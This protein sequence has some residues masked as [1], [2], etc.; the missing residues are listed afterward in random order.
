MVHKIVRYIN[1]PNLERP[2]HPVTEFDTPELHQL[3]D[4]MFETMYASHGL[5][6]AAP[7]IDIHKRLT[8]IDTSGGEADVEPN[9]VILINP[10]NYPQGRQANHERRLPEHPRLPRRSKTSEAGNAQV[11][12]P[13][14]ER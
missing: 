6:L 8:V 5:G 2:A 13:R 4:E 1:N 10:G 11:R 14:R 12:A 7:Q 9:K 3:I